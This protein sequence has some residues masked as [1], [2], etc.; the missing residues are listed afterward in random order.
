MSIPQALEYWATTLESWTRYCGEADNRNQ[1]QISQRRIVKGPDGQKLL[2]RYPG[3]RCL[4]NVQAPDPTASSDREPKTIK[5]R[6]GFNY[7]LSGPQAGQRVLPGVEPP[8]EGPR[9][10]RDPINMINPETG[11]VTPA[12]TQSDITRLSAEGYEIAGESTIP[13]TR[14]IKGDLQKKLLNSQEQSV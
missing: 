2:C 9:Y 5:G 13:L 10:L 4:P 1:S 12:Q 11:K 8:P 7:W 6:D 3:A 14:K